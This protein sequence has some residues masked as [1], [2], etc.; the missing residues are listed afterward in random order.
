[1]ADEGATSGF[2]EEAFP[3][4]P[5]QGI[6]RPLPSSGGWVAL[7]P[8]EGPGEEAVTVRA[9]RPVPERIALAREYSAVIAG[10]A[11]AVMSGAVATGDLT[12][13][14]LAAGER[15]TAG[16]AENYAWLFEYTEDL[17]NPQ[18][19]IDYTY[20]QQG[21]PHV[22]MTKEARRA[23]EMFERLSSLESREGQ[24]KITL[25]RVR[26]PGV[27]SWDYRVMAEFPVG[28]RFVRDPYYGDA[29][30]SADNP[31]VIYFFPLAACTSHA[32]DLL[33]KALRA[34]GGVGYVPYLDYVG[35]MRALSARAGDPIEFMDAETRET[36]SKEVFVLAGVSGYFDNEWLRFR[37]PPELLFDGY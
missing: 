27:P 2:S 7:G 30:V 26:I 24:V 16:R 35:L 15:I 21:E 6:S 1:M 9:K 4:V 20:S 36:R 12:S 22:G 3:N 18:D 14:L 33:Y 5:D 10:H 34:T 13:W 11:R 29:N 31:G 32:C 28:V 25:Q 17:A 37:I 19:E 23:R 8:S